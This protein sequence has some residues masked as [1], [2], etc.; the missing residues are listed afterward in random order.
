MK[1]LR[2]SNRLLSKPWVGKKIECK[3]CG[4]SARLESS[5]K[6][7]LVFNR[8]FA[9]SYYEIDCSCCES[10]MQLAAI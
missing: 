4:F 8:K 6:V 5:D 10:S 2:K 1:T 3:V 7:K 9:T